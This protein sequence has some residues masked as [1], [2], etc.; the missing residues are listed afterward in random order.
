MCFST[1][2]SHW[3]QMQVPSRTYKEEKR[4]SCDITYPH[5]NNIKQCKINNAESS[6]LHTAYFTYT[7]HLFSVILKSNRHCSKLKGD[8]QK[9]HFFM[10]GDSFKQFTTSPSLETHIWPNFN[11]RWRFY[12]LSAKKRSFNQ[13]NL[14]L[15]TL[16]LTAYFASL[17]DNI[18]LLFCCDFHL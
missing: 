11:R 5:T 15:L 3:G 1:L 13:K 2:I 17:E 18:I 8:L 14:H 16:R 10:K 7:A 4:I 6:H 9:N 12:L